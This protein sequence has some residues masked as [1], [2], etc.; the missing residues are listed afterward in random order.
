[1]H[2]AIY[3][4]L[5]IIPCPFTPRPASITTLSPILN[6]DFCFKNINRYDIIKL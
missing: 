6:D 3:Q 5:T 1:M 2:I 4:N